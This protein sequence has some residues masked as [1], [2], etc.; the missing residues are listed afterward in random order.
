MVR[1]IPTPIRIAGVCLVVLTAVLLLAPLVVVVGVSVS[2]SQFVAFPPQGLSFRWY[3]EVLSSDSYL[4]AAV[5]SLWV[6]A[7][8]PLHGRFDRL[9]VAGIEC[10][11]FGLVYPDG[12]APSRARLA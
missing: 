11:Q 1:A 6:A 4:Q 12:D 7:L 5:L 10:G 2:E 9:R 3:R 8:V